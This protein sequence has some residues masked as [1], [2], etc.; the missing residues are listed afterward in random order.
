MIPLV[1]KP[2]AKGDAL[3]VERI[4]GGDKQAEADLWARPEIR[5]TCRKLLGKRPQLEEDARTEA[6]VR[7][8][9][10]IKAGEEIRNLPGFLR[11]ISKNYCLDQIRKL[12]M[13][14]EEPFKEDAIFE[15]WP[16]GPPP[17][18]GIREVGPE[19]ASGL[20]RSLDLIAAF[21]RLKDFFRQNEEE[22]R[23]HL[24]VLEE[25][26]TAKQAIMK[27]LKISDQRL[28]RARFLVRE[29]E[30]SD[31]T[32]EE[33]AEI[34]DIVHAHHSPTTAPGILAIIELQDIISQIPD[35]MSSPLSNELVP[36]RL[37]PVPFA[38]PGTSAFDAIPSM[39]VYKFRMDPLKLIYAVWTR[40]LRKGKYGNHA[41]VV[42]Q[43]RKFQRTAKGTD[44]EFLFRNLGRPETLRTKTIKA[45]KSPTNRIVVDA[46][47]KESFPKL[48]S[49]L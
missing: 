22:I 5:A 18:G 46:I 31:R 17:A 6:W 23:P 25:L 7:A 20:E 35:R 49:T 9:K 29:K 4:R 37:A 24:V 27:R 3:L 44:K 48:V 28:E 11:T 12:G 47:L 41:Q 36:Y 39:A 13:E 30:P 38:G 19:T 1:I 34:R 45:M 42:R 40:A 2:T 14:A 8:V 15:R 43:L 21:F 33:E 26:N 10:A 16:E 32:D